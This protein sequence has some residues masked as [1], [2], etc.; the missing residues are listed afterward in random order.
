LVIVEREA[1]MLDSWHNGNLG[2]IGPATLLLA[3]A[4][5]GIGWYVLSRTRTSEVLL[6][7]ARDA[8]RS[9][10]RGLDAGGEVAEDW[11][12]RVKGLTRREEARRPAARTLRALEPMAGYGA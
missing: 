10:R 8:R 11:V 5:G 12:E 9:V 2:R 6:D 3:L 4:A 7:G 1:E